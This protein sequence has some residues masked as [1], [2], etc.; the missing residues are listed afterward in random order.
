VIADCGIRRLGRTV[1]H[2]YETF[3][4]TCACGFDCVE[5]PGTLMTRKVCTFDGC[6]EFGS[7][8]KTAL[9]GFVNSS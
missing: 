3:P 6:A 5:K 2:S 7:R 4:D 8:C 9:D 1:A